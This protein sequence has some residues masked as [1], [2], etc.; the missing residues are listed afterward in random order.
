MRPLG[1]RRQ[2]VEWGHVPKGD[3]PP[4]LLWSISISVVN[5]MYSRLLTFRNFHDLSQ[6]LCLGH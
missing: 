4:A 3:V 2:A 5:R 1:V 6:T